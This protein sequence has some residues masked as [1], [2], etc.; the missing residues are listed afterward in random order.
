MFRTMI[1]EFAGR[2]F[3]GRGFLCALV[4]VCSCAL[5]F[6]DRSVLKEGQVLTGEILAERQTQLYLDI[7]VTVLVIP[8]EKILEFHYTEPGDIED[9]GAADAN[10]PEG[11]SPGQPR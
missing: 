11:E 7:G 6:S 3:A 5:C 10:D 2:I 8:K 9:V 1:D 4:L